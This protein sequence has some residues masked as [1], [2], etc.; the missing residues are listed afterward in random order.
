MR[1]LMARG[2]GYIFSPAQEIQGDVPA[3]NILALLD[4]ARESA[5]LAGPAPPDHA[6]GD[7]P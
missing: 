6:S 3:E 4:V 1:D 2:G 7:M 5:R